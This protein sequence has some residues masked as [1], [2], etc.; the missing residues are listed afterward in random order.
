MGLKANGTVVY[1]G[2][3]IDVWETLD[4]WENIKIP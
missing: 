2:M 3:S 4:S 1:N